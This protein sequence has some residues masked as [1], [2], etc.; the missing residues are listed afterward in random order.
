MASDKVAFRFYEF[1]I[2]KS[3]DMEE[4]EY[5]RLRCFRNMKRTTGS[6]RDQFA[7]LFYQVSL[8]ADFWYYSHPTRHKVTYI[9]RG[10]ATKQ[11]ASL[12]DYLQY[13]MR[14]Y[15]EFTGMYK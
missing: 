15:E 7:V 12:R 1:D 6:V 11:W 4:L 8:W 9:F 13:L 5:W 2:L 14:K 10:R 3:M